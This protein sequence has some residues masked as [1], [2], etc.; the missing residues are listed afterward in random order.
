MV[1]SSDPYSKANK[2]Y[3]LVPTQIALIF[4][5]QGTTEVKAKAICELFTETEFL[6]HGDLG[7]SKDQFEGPIERRSL[8]D[9]LEQTMLSRE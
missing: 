9:V 2:R 5:S 8:N 7:I 3:S 6:G 1:D 4:L